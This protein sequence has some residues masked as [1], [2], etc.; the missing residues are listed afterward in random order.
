MPNSFGSLLPLGNGV[1]F[2]SLPALGASLSIDLSRMPVS[3]KVL[4]ENLARHEDG[5]TVTADDVAALARWLDPAA[6]G[7]EA[8]FYPARVLIPDSSGVPLPIDLAAMR[9]EMVAG[10]L[11]PRRVGPVVP[12]DLVLDHSVRIDV[13]G[14]PDTFARNL[15]TG[16]E[17][18]R[19]RYGV[20]KWAMAQWPYL[21]AYGRRPAIH[22]FPC[23][24]TAKSWVAACLRPP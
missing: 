11:D 23:L 4:L 22:D 2:H 1:A 17:R 13:S 5:I 6:L 9:D 18:N 7:R 8:A 20:L 21:G 3:L 10:G 16:P 19:E 24:H 15:A 12:T 14:T